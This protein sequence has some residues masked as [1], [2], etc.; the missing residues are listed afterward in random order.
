MEHAASPKSWVQCVINRFKRR[1]VWWYH[2][3][4]TC[5]LSEMYELHKFKGWEFSSIK[6]GE[7]NNVNRTYFDERIGASTVLT[8]HYSQLCTL[9]QDDFACCNWQKMSWFVAHFGSSINLLRHLT[10]ACTCWCICA[11]INYEFSFDIDD[12]TFQWLFAPASAP[13]FNG[14]N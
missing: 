2:W 11:L 5:K 12:V 14:K 3:S 4:T 8:T 9:N 13:Y 6:S 7:S 1:D 10:L